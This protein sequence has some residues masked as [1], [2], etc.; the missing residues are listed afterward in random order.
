MDLK[1]EGLNVSYDEK[2]IL[3]NVSF[4]VKSG[5]IVTIIGPNGSG[6]S[7]LI[8]TISRYL[9]PRSG[10]IYLNK[11][12]INRIHTK[13]IARNL[14]VLPQVKG[15]SSDVSIE[16]LVS[17]GRFPHLK[18]GKR[19]SRDDR[20]IIDWALEKTGLL[21]MK[22]RYVATLSGGERQRAWIAMTLAQKPKMLLL[23]EPT[24]FL[25][26]CYQMETLE[27]VKDLNKM[28]GITVVMVL[29]DINQAARYSDK[30]MIIND[31]ELKEY[32]EPCQIVSKELLKGIFKID[33]DI[34]EDKV[35]GCPYFIPKK[36]NSAG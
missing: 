12:N 6:K 15:V 13:E 26:I 29:H 30:M 35:N 32:G 31:G 17:Y 28:L 9:K 34:Y 5:E 19:M 25:D 20:E 27:M 1:V 21:Q 18:F 11:V 33:A 24:T 22:D 10:D 7:T 2:R 3:K 8:K 36:N 4:N 16:E 23:D 14:A